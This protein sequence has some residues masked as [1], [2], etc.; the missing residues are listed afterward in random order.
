VMAKEEWISRGEKIRRPLGKV[1]SREFS[2]SKF[3]AGGVHVEV[4]FD[5]AFD[6]LPA[7]SETVAF[8]KQD[9]GEWKAT[10]YRVRAAGFARG[11]WIKA[12]LV[13]LFITAAVA[14][15]VSAF[16]LRPSGFKKFLFI[17]LIAAV[18]ALAIRAFFL[19]PFVVATDAATPE[20]PR[21]SHFLV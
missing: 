17:L 1:R 9:G 16:V 3:T 18:I 5:S 4:T 19:Q 11:K 13:I 10:G 8:A 21:G 2:S 14:L 7:A 12:L 6:G 20:I 15:V